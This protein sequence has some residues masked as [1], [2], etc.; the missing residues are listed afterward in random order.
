MTTHLS[1]QSR[2][3][4]QDRPLLENGDRLNRVE[5]ERRYAAA[6]HIK[7]AELIEGVV[8]MAV[9]AL[10]AGNMVQVLA[11]LQQGLTAAEH[12]AFVQQLSKRLQG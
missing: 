11:V 2:P 7:K 8:Y 10:L 4:S 5:F 3:K 6:P 9:E 12:E 1:R